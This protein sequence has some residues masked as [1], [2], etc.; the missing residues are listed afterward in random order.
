MCN[1]DDIYKI[2]WDIIVHINCRYFSK[3]YCITIIYTKKNTDEL[4]I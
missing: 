2:F 4:I 3:E 1:V